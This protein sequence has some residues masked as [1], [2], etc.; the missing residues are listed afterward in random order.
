MIKYRTKFDKIEAVEIERETEKQ[1][2]IPAQ[3][4][5]KA[6]RENKASDMNNWHDTWGAAHAFLVENAQRNVESLRK[7]LELTN[8]KLEQIKGMTQ[9]IIT[10]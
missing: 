10:P 3:G 8:D 4:R 1:V 5:S 9:N 7:Q 2:I 6:R